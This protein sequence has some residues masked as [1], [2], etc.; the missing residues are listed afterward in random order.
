MARRVVY[1]YHALEKFQERRIALE[2]IDRTL[3]EPD[4]TEP[5]PTQPG[6]IRAFKAMAERDFRVLRVVY[7]DEGEDRRVITV[8]FD[9][10]RRR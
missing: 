2:W 9:R 1:T 10:R 4:V 5:D 3:D 6:A 8:F 7:T